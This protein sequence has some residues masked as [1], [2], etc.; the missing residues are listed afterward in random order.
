MN[1]NIKIYSLFFVAFNCLNKFAFFVSLI[2]IIFYLLPC[3]GMI[4]LQQATYNVKKLSLFLPMKENIQFLTPHNIKARAYTYALIK[5]AFNRETPLQAHVCANP[6]SAC[7]LAHP[8]HLL[9]HWFKSSTFIN[10]VSFLTV[11]DDQIN[12]YNNMTYQNP[13]HFKSFA[14]VLLLCTFSHHAPC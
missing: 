3:V 4:L 12:I 8:P 7:S 6:A 11:L 14:I 5:N 2:K 9:L 1:L 13:G 10:S